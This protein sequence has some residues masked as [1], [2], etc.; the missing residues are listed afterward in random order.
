MKIIGI[1]I[2]G[3]TIKTD[4]YDEYGNSL[5][6]FKEVATSINY[7]QHS[8][9]I[10]NQVCEIVAYYI[11]KYKIDGIGISS[12][13]VIDNKTGEVVYAGYTI[14]GYIGT[15][16]KTTLYNKFGLS[17]AVEN[18]VNCAALG[19]IW[20]GEQK[21]IMSA[22]MITVGTG[23]GGSIILNNQIVNGFNFTAG[24]VGYMPIANSDWQSQASTQ[25]LIKLY[26]EKSLK[27]NQNGKLFF[28]NLKS[29]EQ[30][31][32][33]TLN[34]FIHHLCQGLLSI[35][36]LLNPEIII[37][38]GGIFDNKDIL[39][40]KIDKYLND[41]VVNKRFLPKK[42][43]AAKLGNEAGRIGAVKNFLNYY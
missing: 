36:Y 4:I 23:I 28:E 29:G 27:S 40:P 2:G 1:D 17:V 38:G 34:I 16:F 8:N 33:D 12:A 11:E 10:L 21:N 13:G 6:D 24:E 43:I 15:N 5:N 22:V 25:A 3:T 35:S 7:E 9:Q 42:I 18:D 31:A 19:E 37:L 41:K 30:I 14:P 39:L 32:Q 20:L 26:Q